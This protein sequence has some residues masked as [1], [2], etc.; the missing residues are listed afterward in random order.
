MISPTIRLS[1]VRALAC[2]AAVAIVP[3]G[4]P[5]AHAAL[6]GLQ[7]KSTKF[8]GKGADHTKNVATKM[9]IRAWYDQVIA[10]YGAAY[11]SWARAGDRSV[12]CS[13][14]TQ[15]GTLR[16]RCTAWGRPCRLRRVLPHRKHQPVNRNRLR[17]Q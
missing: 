7:C 6:P 10:T 2:A 3:V 1:G 4:G 16:W 9:A 5:P 13:Y 15:P 12:T 8:R 14:A 17:R 11:G